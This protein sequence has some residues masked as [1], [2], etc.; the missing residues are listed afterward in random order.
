MVVEFLIRTR[1]PEEPHLSRLLA[2]VHALKNIGP[3]LAKTGPLPRC[4]DP[5]VGLGGRAV[6]WEGGGGGS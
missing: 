1:E 3:Q 5:E 2:W 4:K 6:G